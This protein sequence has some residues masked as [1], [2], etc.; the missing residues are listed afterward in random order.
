MHKTIDINPVKETSYT[1]Q[2]QEALLR[3]VENEYCAKHRQLSVNKSQKLLSNNSIPSAMASGSGQSSFDPYDLC[4]DVEQ[5]ITPTNVAEMMPGR[6]NRAARLLLGARLYLNSPPESPK[7]WG[8][9]ASNVNDYHSD[10]MEISS[11]LWILDITDW[12]RQQE[13]THSKYAD[14]GNMVHVIFSIIPPGVGV[15][16][17]FSL[18]QVIIGWRQSTTTDETL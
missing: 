6:S 2:H 17:S 14:V 18:A 8:Q 16:A 3:Y 9:V 10:L 11:T 1:M 7:N 5:S 12:W 4:S 15:E 13:E